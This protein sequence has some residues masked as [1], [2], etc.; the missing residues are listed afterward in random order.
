VDSLGFV[1]TYRLIGINS[2]DFAVELGSAHRLNDEARRRFLL[3]YEERKH[4]EFKHPIFGYR[5]TYQ[6]S[7]ELQA[8]LLAKCLQNELDEYPPLLTK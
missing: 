7:F 2:N 3:Q 6:R 8:R 4:T 1:S 5:M